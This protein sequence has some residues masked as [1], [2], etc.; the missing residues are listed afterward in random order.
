MVKIRALVLLALVENQ[1]SV[2]STR[3]TWNQWSVTPDPW[4]LVPSSGL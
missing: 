2:Y 1:G 3:V 4:D